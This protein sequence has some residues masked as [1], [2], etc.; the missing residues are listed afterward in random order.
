[1]E[2]FLYKKNYI[3]DNKN[4]LHLTN[5]EP[6]LRYIDKKVVEL[7]QEQDREKRAELKAN[8]L[9][10]VYKIIKFDVKNSTFPEPRGSFE[11]EN[12]KKLLIN[13]HIAKLS[14]IYYLGNIY[15]NYH[16]NLILNPELSKRI[17]VISNMKTTIRF[18]EIYDRALKEYLDTLYIGKQNMDRLAQEMAKNGQTKP[19]VVTHEHAYGT[20]FILPTLIERFLIIQ[21]DSKI[22]H[23]L[24]E[25]LSQK[26]KLEKIT[27]TEEE[28][29]FYD[30]F[31]S[32]EMVKEIPCSPKY[33]RKFLYDMFLKYKIVTE[34]DKDTKLIFFKEFIDIEN[35]KNSKITLGNMITSKYINSFLKKEYSKLLNM[36]FKPEELNVRNNIAHANSENSDY[37]SLPITAIM[38]Q[39]LWDILR[40]DIFEK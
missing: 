1:M 31:S 34:E 25:E 7:T 35:G 19:I 32:S 17:P 33:G 6:M 30:I 36:L 8:I 26:I 40:E 39:L 13:K 16:T 37:L 3:I 9:N 21:L 12:E 22:M 18:E 38:M 14:F 28:Q 4:N 5:P 2:D 29:K 15:L 20:T 11:S 27:L 23:S 24:F 10:D